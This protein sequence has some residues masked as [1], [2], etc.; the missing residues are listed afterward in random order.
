M[1][2]KEKGMETKVGNDYAPVAI[3][4]G[5]GFYLEAFHI[6]NT[7]AGV[8]RPVAKRTQPYMA[9]TVPAAVKVLAALD[10]AGVGDAVGEEIRSGLERALALRKQANGVPDDARVSV[11]DLELALG[12]GEIGTGEL[13]KAIA[14]ASAAPEAP[15]KEIRA[16]IRRAAEDAYFTAHSALSAVGDSLIVGALD[17]VAQELMDDP[18]A[19]GAE[20]RWAA[21][22]A[23]VDALRKYRLASCVVFAPR[24][25]ALY[26][27][28]HRA[29][30]WQLAEVERRD[31]RGVDLVRSERRGRHTLLWR[32]VRKDYL[33]G[34]PDPCALRVAADFRSEW[35]ASLKSADEMD[36]NLEAVLM[37]EREL[38]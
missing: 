1:A 18:G 27:L 19:R 28:P 32:R 38:G 36:R 5:G 8:E 30:A 20:E 31:R 22:W 10:G 11:R 26:A 9:A 35:R 34:A 15:A 13:A 25:A 17:A 7:Y 3:A 12:A 21:M 33:R 16:S 29:R 14:K 4:E 2:V 6:P 37:A 23:A 24:T